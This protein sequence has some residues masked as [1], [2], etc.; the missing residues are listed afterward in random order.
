MIDCE[1][2]VFSRVHDAIIAEFPNADI[3]S[4]YVRSPST[5]PHISVEMVDNPVHR[6]SLT[7]SSVDDVY[8]DPVFAVNIYSNKTEG[9]KSECKAIAKVIDSVFMGM[10][11]NRMALTPVPNLEDASIYRLTARYRG[12]TDGKYFYR[13]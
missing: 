9:K 4:E 2:E 3:A 12:M 8:A 13:R 10:N 7:M 11:F 6:V 5:F 1:N